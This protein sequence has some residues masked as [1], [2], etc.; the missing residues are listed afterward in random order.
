MIVSDFLSM[1]SFIVM[2]FCL[3]VFIGWFK[4]TI[5]ISHWFFLMMGMGCGSIGLFYALRSVDIRAGSPNLIHFIYYS[6][7]NWLFIVLGT[8]LIALSVIVPHL[9]MKRS[10]NAE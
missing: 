9:V 8:L 6:R 7:F 2:A 10:G 3:V 4:K 5:V 1:F